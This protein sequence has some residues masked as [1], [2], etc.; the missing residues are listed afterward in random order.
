[1]RTSFPGSEPTTRIMQP[2]A[3]ETQLAALPR[4]LCRDAGLIALTAAGRALYQYNADSVRAAKAGSVVVPN[5][6]AALTAYI[7]DPASA[8]GRWE[9][10]LAGLPMEAVKVASGA[11]IANLSHCLATDF[12]GAGQGVT[13]AEGDRVLVRHNSSPDGIISAHGKYQGWYVAGVL[14]GGYTALTRASD[15]DVSAEV[16]SGATTYVVSGASA[17]LV[18]TLTTAPTITLGSTALTFALAVTTMPDAST[19]VVGGT[20]LSVAPASPTSP[21]AVGTNDPRVP[22][23]PSGAGKVPYDNGTAYV[24]AAAGTAGQAFMGGAAPAFA[25]P[26]PEKTVTIAFGDFA[27]LGAGVKTFDVNLGTALPANARI[28]NVSVEAV[29]DFDDGGGSGTATIVVGTSAGG[30][31]VG[32]SMNVALGQSGFPKVLTA[33]AQGWMFAPQASAQLT[34][35]FTSNHDLNTFTAGTATLHARYMI[36]P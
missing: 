34:A 13:L 5:E 31:E 36:L 33:G 15:A 27:A 11:T 24:A 23:T 9:N 30:S 10:M 26:V 14:S 6:I 32:T 2:V 18:Y 22:P 8:P 12:D 29:T 3:D 16:Q 35:R 17:G 1:M 21:I 25:Y 7:A 28:L 19:T 20:K 4:H